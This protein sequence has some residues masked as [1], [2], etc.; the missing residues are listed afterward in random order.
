METTKELAAKVL[1]VVDCGLS[2]GLGEPKPGMMCVEA[3]VCYAMGL[4]HGD[5][6]TCVGKAVRAAKIGLNDAKWSS[7]SARAN[8]MRRVAIAQ[9]GS[10]K[11]DQ[12]RFTALIFE[13]LERLKAKYPP[14]DT[15]NASSYTANASSYTAYAASY[16]ANAARYT[17]YAARYAADAARYTANA[18][19]YT[20]DEV[21]TAFAAIIED[22]LIACGSPGCEWL[23]LAN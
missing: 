19:R 15:A 20:A 9:L 21:L 12:V 2:G 13:G 6:P 10:D 18:A 8:G 3:A 5:E 1:E 23:E 16:I 7:N 14:A 11:I 4:P 22:A 17:A